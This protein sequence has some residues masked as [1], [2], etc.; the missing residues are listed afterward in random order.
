[1]LN[2]L[3][4]IDKISLIGLFAICTALIRKWPEWV[5]ITIS[6]TVVVLLF[7]YV[8]YKQYSCKKGANCTDQQLA[9]M[10]SLG[11]K[12]SDEFGIQFVKNGLFH[13]HKF[14]DNKLLVYDFNTHKFI[15]S[16][17][18]TTFKLIY[19]EKIMKQDNDVLMI[20]FVK[21]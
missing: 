19:N 13:P 18:S 7:I 11:V 10:Q 17:Q 4:I 14:E 6:T 9:L 3:D 8:F 16:P 21:E 1:L 12:D 20:S 15:L 2:K 5:I